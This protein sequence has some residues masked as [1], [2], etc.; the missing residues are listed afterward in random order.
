MAIYDYLPT[1]DYIEPNNLKGL[2]P[3]FVVAQMEVADNTLLVEGTKL[4]AN[5]AI[6]E[7]KADGIHAATANTKVPFIHYTEP[8]NTI[9]NS[10]KYFAVD[11]DAECPRLVQLI[12]GDE[13]MSSREL[14]EAEL[15]GGRI[16][17]VTSG[18]GWYGVSTMANGDEGHHYVFL[19]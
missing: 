8:L 13:W 15:L 14:S 11:T 18:K 6:C 10:D 4:F 5:G 17:K 12:P 19:G 3:G 2:Q 7:I 1:F 9:L 16:V